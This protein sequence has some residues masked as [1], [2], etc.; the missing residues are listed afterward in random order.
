MRISLFGLGIIGSIWARNWA[1]DGHQIKTWNR[2]PKPDSPGWTADPARA[3]LDAELVAITV[4]DGA[5]AL[6]ILDRIKPSL[7]AGMVVVNSSTIGVD[8]T[9]ELARRV[10]A[11][12]ASFCDLP[13][14]GSKL[15]AEAR[16][17]VYY[18]GDD[19]HSFE[20]V[21][22]AY[23]SLSKAILPIGGVGQAMALKLSLN[24]LVAV[25]YQA[26]AESLHLARS[27]GLDAAKFF[28][29]L[30]QHVCRSGLTELKRPLLMSGN[31]SPQ[32]SIRNMHKDLRLAI[33]LAEE[34][35]Q[36]LPAAGCVEAAYAR[37]EAHNLGEQDFSAM[38]QDLQL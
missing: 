29:V 11:A 14:V 2:S 10:R 20:R 21:A 27:A 24:L 1:A 30:D 12:G 17:H 5:A 31:F 7:R 8:E 6:G 32:F 4:S 19:D 25:S 13:F 28:S 37:A 3:A 26:L 18:L 16:Q 34:L 36:S 9:H 33:G 15:A 35:Q 22:A 23:R 38:I